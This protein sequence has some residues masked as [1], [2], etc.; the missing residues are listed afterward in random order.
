MSSNEMYLLAANLYVIH[1]KKKK[2]VFYSLFQWVVVERGY[3]T[4]KQETRGLC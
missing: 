3:W 4:E 1:K 2:R